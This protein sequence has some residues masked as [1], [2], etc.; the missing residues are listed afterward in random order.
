MNCETSDVF[1][2]P[3]SFRLTSTVLSY[4]STLHDLVKKLFDI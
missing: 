4:F 1:F 3:S 2:C